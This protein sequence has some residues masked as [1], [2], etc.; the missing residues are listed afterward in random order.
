M[1]AQLDGL[2]NA[3]N[4][5][6][7]GIGEGVERL[8][9]EANARLAALLHEKIAAAAVIQ[10]AAETGKDYKTRIAEVEAHNEHSSR[11]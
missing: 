2:R 8:G 11:K 4:G 5:V 1:R 6:V 9:A 7:H 10:Q 3:A